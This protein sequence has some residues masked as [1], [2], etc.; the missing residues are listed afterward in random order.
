[1]NSIK[2]WTANHTTTIVDKVVIVYQ[3]TISRGRNMKVFE[4]VH[5]SVAMTVGKPCAQL[6]HETLLNERKTVS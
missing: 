5:Y 1:M 6:I 4:P 2:A 3:Q